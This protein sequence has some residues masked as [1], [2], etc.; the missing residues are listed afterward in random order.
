MKRR[1][2]GM[3]EVAIVFILLFLFYFITAGLRK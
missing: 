1:A 2:S 3:G